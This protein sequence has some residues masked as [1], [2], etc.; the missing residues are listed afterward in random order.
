MEEQIYNEVND[1]RPQV[2]EHFIGQKSIVLRSK[3]A[4]ESAWNQGTKLPHML[5]TGG[6][7]LG[8][9]E[10]SHILA[11]EMGCELHEQLAQNIKDQKDL[12]SF[13]L[14]P[15]D[16][17]VILLDEIHELPAIAQTTLYRAMENQQIFLECKRG[18]KSRPLKIANFTILAATTDPHKLLQPLRDRFK[19]ILDYQFYTAQ[20]LEAMLRTRVQ[21]L[22]WIVEDS[23]FALISQRGKGVP[24][25][26][27]RLLESV[28]MLA[29]SM[30]EEVIRQDHFHRTCEIES[31]DPKGLTHN[32]VQ[33]L[34]IL[35]END[36]SARLNIIASRLGLNSKHVSMIIE[37]F[38]IRTGLVTKNNSIRV[39]TQ[40]GLKH[41][42][43]FH[44]DGE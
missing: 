12:Q 28:K 35:Y 23:V 32:E 4:L 33:Y 3:I 25:I 41:L 16:R 18:K 15:K 38:L 26:T 7:G 37:Q 39:L 10:L 24:R 21:Q 30:N 20:E 36:G 19:L 9:T 44:C 42:R 8:K 11:K 29:S 14:T 1:C 27:L 31:I 13:L 34:N 5:M 40:D 17:E 2:I 43:E 6:P 22:R